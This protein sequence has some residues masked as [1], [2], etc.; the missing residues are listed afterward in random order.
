MPRVALV[1][2]LLTGCFRSVIIDEQRQDDVVEQL[3]ARQFKGKLETVRKRF[4]QRLPIVESAASTPVDELLS[5]DEV[6]G[7]K[8]RLCFAPG[9]DDCAEA[10][11][12]EGN[13]VRFA[14]ACERPD[15]CAE[16]IWEALAPGEVGNAELVARDRSEERATVFENQFVPRW[17]LTGG[18]WGGVRSYENVTSLGLRFGVRRWLDPYLIAGALLEYE[19][20]FLAQPRN[21][22]ALVARVEMATYMKW[23][24]QH[25]QLPEASAYLFFAPAW[26]FGSKN[27]F[28]ARA[29]I[30]AQVV[31]LTPVFM[32]MGVQTLFP[33]QEV[34]VIVRLGMGV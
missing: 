1:S 25:W 28:G 32:E 6:N 14:L 3:Q 2:L 19:R 31:R 30:G 16:R 22:L 29:G 9:E 24:A 33:D 15:H 11:E 20:T 23:S 7:T 5:V 17:T 13:K 34:R 10:N 4:K 8:W 27:R 21:Q 12:L 26:D 18:A